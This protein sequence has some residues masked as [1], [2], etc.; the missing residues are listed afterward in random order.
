MSIWDWVYSVNV[1]HFTGNAMFDYF[2]TLLCLM[3][4]LSFS[5]GILIKFFAR[6]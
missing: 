5:V 2:F 3:G 1:F 6:S 4:L